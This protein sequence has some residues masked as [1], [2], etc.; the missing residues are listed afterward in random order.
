MPYSWKKVWA[1]QT[2][3]TDTVQPGD[4]IAVM[5]SGG[6]SKQLVLSVTV[7]ETL[8]GKEYKTLLTKEVK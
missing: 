1:V 7:M 3:A 5:G 4:E 2:D 6:D 8:K